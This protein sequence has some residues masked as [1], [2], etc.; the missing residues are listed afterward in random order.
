MV[1]S[2]ILMVVLKWHDTF[3]VVSSTNRHSMNNAI[4]DPRARVRMRDMGSELSVD[5]HLPMNIEMALGQ[6]VR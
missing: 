4:A 6:A 3:V 2:Q 5:K 1:M